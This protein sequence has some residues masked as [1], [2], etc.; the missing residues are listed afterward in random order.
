MMSDDDVLTGAGV[1]S[2]V[3]DEIKWMAKLSS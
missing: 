3:D 2:I 1:S